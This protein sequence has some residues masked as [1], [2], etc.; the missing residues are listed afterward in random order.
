MHDEKVVIGRGVL[1]YTY[2]KNKECR[3]LM[4]SYI[5]KIYW[6]IS[7]KENQKIYGKTW[8]EDSL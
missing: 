8:L 4:A 6:S 1:L 3:H 7:K 5:P 2:N